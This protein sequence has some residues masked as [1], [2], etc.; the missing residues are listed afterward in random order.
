M[1]DSAPARPGVLVVGAGSAGVAAAIAS[2]ET[3]ADTLLVEASG[4]VGGTLARQ[5]LEHSAGFHDANGNQVTGGVGQRIITLLQD[6]GG[7]PGHIRDDTAYTATRTPVNHAELAICE[8]ILLHRAGVMLMLNTFV[9]DVAADAGMIRRVTTETPGIG[10]TTIEPAVVV[11]CSGDAVVFELAGAAFQTDRPSAT[12]P[13]SLLLK[14]GGV[15]FGP[16]MR[17]AA[18]HPADFRAGGH[19]GSP[20]DEHVNLWGFGR[21]LAA[22]H[23]DGRLSWRRTELHLAGWPARGEAVLNLTRA[24]VDAV[25]QP[26]AAYLVLAQQVMQAVSWF[27]DY[28]PGGRRA[29]LAHV[30]DRVGVRESRRIAGLATLTR[31]DVV[32]GLHSDQSIGL[33]AFPIDVHDAASPGMSHADC[34][35]AAYDIPYGILVARDFTNLLAGGRCVST[36]HEANGSARITA[37]CFTTGEAAGCAAALVGRDGADARHID[38]GALQAHLRSR[39]VIGRW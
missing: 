37:T 2:A 15:D 14:L 27:R 26:G 36:T 34:L 35:T 21:L 18:G 32:G 19:I 12:Q 28:V 17:Y 39:G 6:Y 23:A 31:E 3:G 10:R 9:V 16:L 20:H 7:S 33:G 38:V 5:L 30:A 1:S 22:G 24:T 29:Y 13:A 4:H 25:H 11:D 8:A